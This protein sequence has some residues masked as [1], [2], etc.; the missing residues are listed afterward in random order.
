ML[1]VDI[2]AL[3]IHVAA[4]AEHGPALT[5]L[6]DFHLRAMNGEIELA[7]VGANV[8]CLAVGPHDGVCLVFP[9]AVFTVP[10]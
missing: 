9:S 5:A 1:L 2:R 7:A 4:V 10:R 8:E 3:K 6:F